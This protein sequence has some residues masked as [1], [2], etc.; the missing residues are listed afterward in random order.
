[1]AQ[2]EILP[3]INK[4]MA[5]IALTP[6]VDKGTG[7][8]VVTARMASK[9]ISAL[10]CIKTTLCVVLNLARVLKI[11]FAS[12]KENGGVSKNDDSTELV[13]DCSSL[14]S[15]TRHTDDGNHSFADEQKGT[16][17][18]ALGGR[19]SEEVEKSVS[20]RHQLLE[21]IISA[22]SNPALTEIMNFVTDIFTESTTYCKNS[23][24]MRHQECFALKPNTDG[25][26][27]I[28]RKAY[29]ANVDDIYRF[30][31]E[32]A[33]TFGTTIAVKETTARG[34]FLSMPNDQMTLPSVFIQP[35]KN[36]K[37]IHCTTEDVSQIW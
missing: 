6:D 17:T 13:D 11:Q 31:D 37:F 33:E 26:M 34:Y 3:D 25:I 2:L 9:G 16:L 10:V 20:N 15:R 29:L 7:K 32:Y 28:L 18:M 1:M 22:L 27:D 21:A 19:V 8:K 5:H 24:A 30:A 35:V 12:L 36:G 14:S 4:M 23:H